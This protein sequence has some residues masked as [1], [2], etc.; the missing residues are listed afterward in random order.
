M[1]EKIPM[2]PLEERQSLVKRWIAALRSGNYKQGR[3]RLKRRDYGDD[4]YCCLGVLVE[5]AG[6]KFADQPTDPDDDFAPYHGKYKDEVCSAALPTKLAAELGID[7]FGDPLKVSG[8]TEWHKKS[9]SFRNDNGATFEDIADTLENEP[10][11]YLKEF[12]DP[13]L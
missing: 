11:K 9:L 5:V 10:H 6:G 4:C 2:L 3:Q 12:P 7:P 1:A 8:E 13:N